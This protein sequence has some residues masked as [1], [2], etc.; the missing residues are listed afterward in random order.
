MPPARIGV[1]L[2]TEIA[3]A[4]PAGSLDYWSGRLTSEKAAVRAVEKR[5]GEVTLPLT[6]PHGLALALVETSDP[7]EF[8]PWAKSPVP[9]DR[10]ILGLHSVRLWEHELATTAS[11]LTSVL[12][13]THAGEDDGWH[14]YGL[15]NGGS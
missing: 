15:A 6:D 7:R 8:T 1:G 11:F 2:G 9:A 12:G 5:F 14:R 3:L 10:Q 4:I 13:F